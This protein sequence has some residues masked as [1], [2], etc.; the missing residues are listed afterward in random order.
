MLQSNHCAFDIITDELIVLQIIYTHQTGE[1]TLEY[2]VG[3]NQQQQKEV[4]CVDKL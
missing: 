4:I 1:V 3:E 2:G